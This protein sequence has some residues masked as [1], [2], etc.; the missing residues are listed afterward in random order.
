MDAFDAALK[1]QPDN[2]EAWYDSGWALHQLQRYEEAVGSFD[3]AVRY[4]SD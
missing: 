4:K 1:I 2:L 3:Q